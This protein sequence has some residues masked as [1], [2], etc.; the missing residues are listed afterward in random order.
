MEKLEEILRAEEN[1]RRELSDAR[2]RARDVRKEAAAE[3]DLI[4]QSGARKAADAAAALRSKILLEA[5]SQAAAIE[6]DAEHELGRLVGVAERQLDTAVD[7]VVREVT[8]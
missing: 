7:D 1:A 3:A 4:L 5:D 8:G 6:R 2:A